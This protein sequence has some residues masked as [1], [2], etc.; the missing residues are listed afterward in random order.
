MGVHMALGFLFLSG[1]SASL[2]LF[3]CLNV[4]IAMELLILFVLNKS[5]N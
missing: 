1:S 2:G 5:D 4:V 3:Y